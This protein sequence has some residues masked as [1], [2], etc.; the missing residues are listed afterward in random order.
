MDESVILA[1]LSK[2]KVPYR[3]F[4][5]HL[6]RI[7]WALSRLGLTHIPQ[8]ALVRAVAYR[9]SRGCELI[10]IATMHQL[11]SGIDRVCARDCPQQMNWFFGTKDK[12]SLNKA[13]RDLQSEQQQHQVQRYE[14]KLFL[15]AMLQQLLNT[16]ELFEQALFLH[17][18][19][20][21]LVLTGHQ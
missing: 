13:I 2:G 5:I 9:Y 10:D 8:E 18:L 4:C 14:A 20:V 16:K 12:L 1:M 11:T 19:M 15:Q 3:V 7:H 6:E 17:A 21:F